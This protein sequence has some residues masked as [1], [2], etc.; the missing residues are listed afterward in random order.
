MQLDLKSVSY[1]YAPNTSYQTKALDNI[2]LTVNG[3]EFIG[4]MGRTGCGKSTLLQI[5]DGLLVPDSGIVML[6]GQDINDEKYDR[7]VLRSS[8]GLVFQY[9]EYQLFETTVE[10][11]VAFALKYSGLSKIEIKERVAEAL[12]AAG[13][14]YDKV[15]S[16]SP[17][18]FS[19]GEKKRLAIAGVLAAKPD[20][21]ILDEPIAGLDCQGKTAFLRLIK[22]LNEKGITII[23]ISH[24]SD[25][26]AEYASRIILMD[27]GRIIRDDAAESV[28]SDCEMLNEIGVGAGNIVTVSN[29][30]RQRGVEI[31]ANTVKYNQLLDEIT[32]IYGG[33]GI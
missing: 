3:G 5:I 16:K 14:D 25:V 9:P 1:T 6:D 29:M 13:F 4:I 31:N 33:A 17:L 27:K 24:D 12:N 30:L 28:L 8:I 11:D 7:A 21:L 32:E 2:N 22:S 15:K 20:V 23:M 18:S 19:G 26:L 10:R